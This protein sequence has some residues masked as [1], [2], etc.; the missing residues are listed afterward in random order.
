VPVLDQDVSEIAELRLVP[1]RLLMEER[2][3]VGDRGVRSV[4]RTR[5]GSQFFPQRADQVRNCLRRRASRPR[6]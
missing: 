4:L 1:L 6:P 3:R 2:I 5:V